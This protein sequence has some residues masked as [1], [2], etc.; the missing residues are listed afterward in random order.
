[1]RLTDGCA[2]AEL[3][4]EVDIA[5]VN[6]C[7][8]R[9]DELVARPHG[10]VVVDLSGVSFLDC[11]GLR[12]LIRIRSGTQ[13]HGDRLAVVCAEPRVLRLFR[14]T[15]LQGVFRPV[16]TLLAAMRPG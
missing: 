7:A 8:P 13:V 6:R 1:M 10:L 9:L 4:G 2:V 3:R 12:M 5:V 16:P 14:L 11:A 15:G